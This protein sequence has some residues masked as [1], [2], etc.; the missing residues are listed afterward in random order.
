MAIEP[1][2]AATQPAAASAA[3]GR[4]GVGAQSSSG[5]RLEAAFGS[6]FVG[7]S[8]QWRLNSEFSPSAQGNQQQSARG[9]AAPIVITPRVALAA[10]SFPAI[11]GLET[12][13]DLGP[14]RL[15]PSDL[16]LAVGTYE[17]NM[18]I[19]SGAQRDQGS[20]VNRFS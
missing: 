14:K 8:D 16:Q 20:V 18:R 13:S 5:D 9:Q 17:Y 4:V 10:A 11:T 3:T 1:S 12:E 2:I 19:T 7:L 6:P 15:T